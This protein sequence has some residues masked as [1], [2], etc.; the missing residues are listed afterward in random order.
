MAP[1]GKRVGSRRGPKKKPSLQPALLPLAAGVTLAVV[2]WGYLVYAAIDFGGTARS[3]EQNAWW[4][5]ALAS[6]GAVAC[7]FVGLMLIARLLRR[8][9]I[10]GG[11]SSTPSAPPA[12]PGS[13][14]VA[15]PLPPP[16]GGR[17]ASR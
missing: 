11:A 6:L 15:P 1:Q 2:A 12:D 9:G 8:L 14:P 13:P 16:P 3:G 10:T 7:L 5:L 4:F 17:R